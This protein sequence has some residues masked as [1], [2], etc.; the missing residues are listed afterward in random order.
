MLDD[1]AAGLLLPLPFVVGGEPIQSEV[2]GVLDV[3]LEPGW[4]I[5]GFRASPCLPELAHENG[6]VDARLL[7]KLPQNRILG[8][9]PF[10]DAAA[11]HLRSGVDI[12]VVEDQQPA[13]GIGHVGHGPLIAVRMPAR[14]CG[15][16]LCRAGS[17]TAVSVH[18]LILPYTRTGPASW[19]SLTDRSR[20][21][22]RFGSCDRSG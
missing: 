21:R 3:F 16:L 8:G 1:V 11:G 14:P 13:V 15:Q 7:S 5:S 17:R 20:I 2:E 6:S 22:W 19:P 10:V 4:H 12:D 9:L 18:A